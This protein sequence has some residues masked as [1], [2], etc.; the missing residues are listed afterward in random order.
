MQRIEVILKHIREDALDIQNFIE[1]MNESEFID[2][3]LVR[4]RFVCL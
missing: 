4:K 1:G 3:L 2:N